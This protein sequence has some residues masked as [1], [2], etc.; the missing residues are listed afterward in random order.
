MADRSVKVILG[1]QVT[2]LVNGVR[3]AKGAVEDFGKSATGWFDKNRA[4]LDQISSSAIKVGAG[5]VA[6]AGFAVKSAMDWEQAWTGVLKTVDGTGP[7]LARLEDDLRSLAKE[8]GFAH[9]EVAA[10]AEAAGQ[11]GIS[12]E[13]VADFA[14]TMLAMGVSTNLTAEEAATTLARFRNIMGSTEP[15]IAK[16]GATIVGLG[17]NFATTEAEIAAMSLRIGG[18]GRQVGLTEA[19]VMGLSAAMSSVGI[20]AEAGGTALSLTMK[21]VEREVDAGGSKLQMFADVAGMSAEQFSTKWKTDAAGALTDFVAG[22]STVDER[23][24]SANAVLTELGIT[25]IREADALLRLSGNAQGLAEALGMA[26][27]EW[28][29]GTALTEEAAKFY[30]TTGQ[31]AKQAMASIR[32]AAIGAGDALLPAISGMLEGVAAI[33]D[34]FGSLPGPVKGTVTALTGVSG[35]TLIAAG[36]LIKLAGSARD[37]MRALAGLAEGESFSKKA[38]LIRA[39]AGAAGAALIGFS[40]K[41]GETN[42][43]LGMLSETAGYAAMG[44]AVGGPWGAAIG[45][46]IGLVKSLGSAN[47]F[48]SAGVEALT[49]SLDAQTGAITSNTRKLVADAIEESGSFDFAGDIGVSISEMT[50]AALGGE[51][52]MRK[53]QSSLMDTYRAGDIGFF[54][55]TRLMDVMG[56]Q[57]S[58]VADSQKGFEQVSE[59]M[60]GTAGSA[61][62]LGGKLGELGA[63][64]HASA[65]E[66]EKLRDEAQSLG[67]S[68][69]DMSDAINGS[70]SGFSKTLE[71]QAKQL[72]EFRNNAVKALE[73]GADEDL[74][75]Y[76]VS[77][78]PEAAG[79]LAN[80]AD[81]SEDAVARANAAFGEMNEQVARFVEYRTGVDWEVAMQFKTAGA[82]DAIATAVE[83]AQSLGLADED[84][85]SVLSA[86]DYASED[87]LAVLEL[88]RE[89]DRAEAMSEVAANVGPALGPIA[90]VLQ[91]MDLVDRSRANPSVSLS[92]P[93]V[94]STLSQITN[95]MRGLAM[96]GPV[97]LA[98]DV[99]AR[100]SAA[101]ANAIGGFY[102]GGVRA[103]AGGGIDERGRSVPRQPQMRSGSQGAVVW[104]EAETGWE[105]YVSGK[106]GMQDRNRAVLGEAAARLGGDVTWYANGGF[107]EAVSTTEYTRLRIRVRD[108]ERDLR[109]TGDDRLRGLDKTLAQRELRD[110]KAALA[111][112]RSANLRIPKGFTADTWNDARSAAHDF[113]DRRMDETALVSPASFE[114]HMNT[115]LAESAA[116]T[117][118][119]ADLKKKGAS[120]WLLEQLVAFGPSKSSIRTARALAKDTA[121]LK[122]MNAIAGQMDQVSGAYGRMTSDPR[123]LQASAAGQLWSSAQQR[124]VANAAAQV[125]VQQTVQP[126][127][128]MSEEQV[129]QMSVS[130]I[131][132]ALR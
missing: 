45:G 85:E 78:G 26:S 114:R 96:M 69:V 66:T 132:Q 40:D 4:G 24:Q 58:E 101:N 64:A 82:D 131:M 21:R 39:G 30:G 118:A 10:V 79:M 15:D 62:A 33:A 124:A 27:E 50:D 94:L 47:E 108:L 83:V 123:W 117:Q 14:E 55:M 75:S 60:E 25:G 116:F 44:F 31:Q 89:A 3:T 77:M 109:A 111:R 23:G 70:L 20:E 16:M 54:E 86:L 125:T 81:A 9:D 105:A 61:D 90:T 126:Q 2:G 84:V 80:L 48:A 100:V 97:S 53:L 98:L 88:M 120:P 129:A 36:G 72:R 19:Q 56:E 115:M 63:E 6:V 106:P 130:K 87:I 99:A 73:R 102:E 22:L 5:L 32:D 67:W 49:A 34:A 76:L 107:N 65:E 68:F 59:A 35:I 127:P 37:T 28:A 51:D 42:R 46:A 1:S 8:T 18:A 13:G 29:R 43:S 103:F 110:A 91:M 95:M 11:L 112:A 128:G 52:A 93:G 121:R 104:G 7:Q 74:V 92:A 17:N 113:R 38:M 41:I 71:D 122:R 119:L 12:T 57:S